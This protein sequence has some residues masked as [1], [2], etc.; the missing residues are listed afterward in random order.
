MRSY[1]VSIQGGSL[2][3]AATALAEITAGTNKS[4]LITRATCSQQGNTTSAQQGIQLARQ[5]TAGTNVLSPT[6]SPADPGDSAATFTARGLCTVLGTIGAVL[7]ADS[8][9]WQN[10][11]SLLP[12]P[13]ERFAVTGAGI[14]A[15]RTTTTPP[16]QTIT[17][18][19]TV[20]E[21]G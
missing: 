6:I 21:V 18:V 16:V 9:N 12:V 20:L 11:W 10:G 1:D 19:L 4:C 14:V 17:S 2:T 15:L 8:F 5:S 7:F 3:A 13:E